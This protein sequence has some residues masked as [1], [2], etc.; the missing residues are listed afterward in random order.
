MD[1]KVALVD[2]F[3]AGLAMLRQCAEVCPDDLWTEGEY[4]R[5]FWRIA[6][7]GL[8]Y[9]ELYLGQDEAAFGEASMRWTEA[10]RALFGIGGPADSIK[11]EPYELPEET[12]APD[13][14]AFIALLDRVAATVPQVVAELDLDRGET[15]FNW[16]PNMTKLSHELLNL[17]H[18][19]GHVGQLSELL[20]AAGVEVD[21]VS[22]GRQG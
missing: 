12:P 6:W 10:T 2:Q 1:V 9:T 4:P 22:R 20:M 17:R 13:R 3:L 15:G 16:Y 19:Q 11:V 21:W 18:L 5:S 14:G 7:H 8:F